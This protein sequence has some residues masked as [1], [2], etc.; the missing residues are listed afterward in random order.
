[1]PSKLTPAQQELLKTLYGKRKLFSNAYNLRV[2]GETLGRVDTNS[3]QIIPKTEIAGIDVFV[4]DNSHNNLIEI[5]VLIDQSGLQDKVYNDFY[6]GENTSTTILAGCGLHNDEAHKTKHVGIHRFFVAHGARVRYIESHYGT[7]HPDGKRVL[8]PTTIAH[9][10]AESIFEIE[11]T[12]IEG[13]DATKRVTEATIGDSAKLIIREKIMT[14]GK[15]RAT[16]SYAINLNGENSG[17]NLISRSV[18]KAQSWQ[19]FYSVINGNNKCAG[20]SACDAIVMDNATVKAVP[21]VTANHSKASLVHEAAI[22]R[23]AKDQITKL[24][25]FGIPKERAEMIIIGGF[26][27]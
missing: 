22:G 12:Q 5:P 18:A 6:I 20:H 17:S 27:K 13:I 19:G 16:T 25:T 26:L 2:N 8:N 23:I 9:L 1:M 24:M 15:Q 14:S 21:D 11:T 4:A 7:G 10:G 3:V